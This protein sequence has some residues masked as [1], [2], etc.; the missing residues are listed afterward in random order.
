MGRE[1]EITCHVWGR[2]G[3]V[4]ADRSLHYSA[5]YKNKDP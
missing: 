5:V 4:V 2:D 1:R 3:R